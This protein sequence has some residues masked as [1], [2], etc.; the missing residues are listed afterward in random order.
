MSCVFSPIFKLNLGGYI[1]VHHF[2]QHQQWTRKMQ[3]RLDIS[4]VTDART[5]VRDGNGNV[6][7]RFQ[8]DYLDPLGRS[9]RMDMLLT[10]LTTATLVQA[11]ALW[12]RRADAPTS[13]TDRNGATTT[14]KFDPLGLVHE[15][16]SP[17]GLW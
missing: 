15:V 4:N 8:P 10:L 7:N 2:L 12:D 6:P 16:T 5:R 17:T 9:V 11:F 14:T 3:L 13:A 1:S